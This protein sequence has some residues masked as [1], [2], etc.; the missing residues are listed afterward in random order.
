MLSHACDDGDDE[1]D[2]NA[3]GIQALSHACDDD[4]HAGASW[5]LQHAALLTRIRKTLFRS[6]DTNPYFT[7]HLHAGDCMISV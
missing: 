6:V 7:A 3:G 1:N 5:L 2:E 4:E